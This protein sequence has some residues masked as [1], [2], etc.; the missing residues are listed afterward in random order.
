[1]EKFKPIVKK[2]LAE[3]YT[4]F[5]NKFDE[6]IAKHGPTDLVV[7]AE[8]GSFITDFIEPFNTKT[9]VNEG[10][11][12]FGLYN[13]KLRLLIDPNMKWG[14]RRFL[15]FNNLVEYASEYP[16]DIKKTLC[17]FNDYSFELEYNGDLI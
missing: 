2:Y 11:Y 12:Q 3:L 1:M 10:I 9:I 13:N 4:I 16:D 8:V 7:S 15:F 5:E 14:D 17:A 6:I